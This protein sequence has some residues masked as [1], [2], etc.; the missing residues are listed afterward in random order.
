MTQLTEQEFAQL[1]EVI[2]QV[3]QMQAYLKQYDEPEEL[4]FNDK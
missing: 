4:D 1:E 3:K 2:K